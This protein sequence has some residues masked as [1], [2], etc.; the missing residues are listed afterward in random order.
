[1]KTGILNALD[2]AFDASSCTHLCSNPMGMWEHFQ[3][4]L[5]MN[6]VSIFIV[7]L[8]TGCIQISEEKFCQNRPVVGLTLYSDL[9]PALPTKAGSGQLP[10]PIPHYIE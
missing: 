3:T 8:H 6:L 10:G 2:I 5:I 1:M 4:W 7:G 9:Y